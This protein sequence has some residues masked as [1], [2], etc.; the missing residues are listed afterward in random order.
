LRL[1][2]D[3]KSVYIRRSETDFMP[4]EERLQRSGVVAHGRAKS[5]GNTVGD[6]KGQ[7]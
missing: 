2:R 7:V 6:A 4:R 3:G 1:L 5:K